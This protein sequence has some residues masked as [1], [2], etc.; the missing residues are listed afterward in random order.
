[1]QLFWILFL[2]FILMLF[3][4]PELA[5]GPHDASSDSDFEPGQ[6]CKAEPSCIY[7][8]LPMRFGY[9][10]VPQVPEF[11][12]LKTQTS[13]SSELVQRQVLCVLEK[14]VLKQPQNRVS[15]ATAVIDSAALQNSEVSQKSVGC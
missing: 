5:T 8:V 10:S 14:K 4:G 2:Y 7:Q 6:M 13:C 12:T 9:G 15:R 11:L 1:M 3:Q